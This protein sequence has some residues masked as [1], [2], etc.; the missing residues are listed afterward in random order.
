MILDL[1]L[2]TKEKQKETAGVIAEVNKVKQREIKW[3]KV[4]ENICNSYIFK[5]LVSKIYKEFIQLKSKQ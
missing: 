5:G 3:N 1:I 4:E 2:N